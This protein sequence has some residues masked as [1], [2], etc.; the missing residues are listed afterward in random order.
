M[1]NR[2]CFCLLQSYNVAFMY[3]FSLAYW[4]IAQF[5]GAAQEFSFLEMQDTH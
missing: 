3:M 5:P 1:L 2:G 4:F